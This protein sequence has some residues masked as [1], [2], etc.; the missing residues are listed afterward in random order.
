MLLN[1]LASS[2][3]YRLVLEER[4][5]DAASWRRVSALG[6]TIWRVGAFFAR[7]AS[8]RV[9][10]NSATLS[11]IHRVHNV[12]KTQIDWSG[13]AAEEEVESCLHHR[14]NLLRSNRK[15][16]LSD[17]LPQTQSS[18]NK[19][20]KGRSCKERSRGKAY[21]SKDRMPDMMHLPVSLP[22]NRLRSYEKGGKQTS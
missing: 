10:I 21:R 9:F 1:V 14:G 20:C 17:G 13:S 6:E 5:S 12:C 8:P 2:L 15:R 7:N 18:K 3:C 16:R 19:T 11:D 22:A 4:G